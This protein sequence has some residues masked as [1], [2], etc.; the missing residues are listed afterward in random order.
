MEFK[1]LIYFERV[2]EL[3]GFSKAAESLGLSQSALSQAIRHLEDQLR[4]TLLVRNGRGVAL[5]DEGRLLL[6]RS[7][8]I[9]EH[10]RR[11]EEEVRDFNRSPSG[12]VRLGCSHAVGTEAICQIVNIFRS[13]FERASLEVIEVKGSTA[14]EWLMAGRL[15]IGILYD[16][17]PNSSIESMPIRQV[18]LYLASAASSTTIPINARVPFR[19]LQNHPLILPGNT[20]NAI[21]QVLQRNAAKAGIKITPT[22]RVE[23]SAFILGLVEQGFGYSVLPQHS[24]RQSQFSTSIQINELVSPSLSWTLY[25]AMSKEHRITDLIKHTSEICIGVLK[26][27][28]AV[29]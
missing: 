16:P 2:A 5:T 18:P 3:G 15:D 13:R 24:V 6:A 19:S 4:H 23:G 17:P 26:E 12:T 1:Q 8:D 14:Y 29:N 20:Q 28:R 27:E 11:T 7:K 9:L 22:M 25:L 21:N 10:V